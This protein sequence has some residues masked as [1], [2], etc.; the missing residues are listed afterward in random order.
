MKTNNRGEYRISKYRGKRR[1]FV[2]LHLAVNTETKQI[3]YCDVTNEEIPDGK[4]LASMVSHSSK[5]GKINNGYFDAGY[6]SK[7]NYQFLKEKG[8]MPVIR[9]RHSGSLSRTK[10]RINKIEKMEI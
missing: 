8:I 2:K 3:V 6:D 4:K 7:N 10:E 9:P 1:K 5:Y